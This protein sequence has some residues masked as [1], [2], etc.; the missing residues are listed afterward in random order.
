MAICREQCERKP[1]DYDKE[2]VEALEIYVD[3]CLKA[4]YD[5]DDDHHV[6]LEH[7]RSNFTCEDLEE[8]KR[9]YEAVGWRVKAYFGEYSYLM[10]RGDTS[11]V[12]QQK[13]AID[14]MTMSLLSYKTFTGPTKKQ[15]KKAMRK[16]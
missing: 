6:W 14:K 4:T 9:R 10:F 11:E 13:S 12:L 7:I 3:K 8:L 5:G 1:V 16:R 2:R 15:I